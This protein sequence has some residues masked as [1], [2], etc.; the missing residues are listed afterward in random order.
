MIRTSFGVGLMKI[1]ILRKSDFKCFWETSDSGISSFGDLKICFSVKYDRIC[2]L[3]RVREN[4]I[5]I[6]VT[7]RFLRTKR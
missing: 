2:R 7:V 3:E 6:G 4:G 1:E 5:G